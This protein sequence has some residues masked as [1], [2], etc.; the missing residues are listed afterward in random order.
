MA[1][2]GRSDE[3]QTTKIKEKVEPASCDHG[4]LIARD[5]AS[6]E[7]FKLPKQNRRSGYQAR[8]LL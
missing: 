7:P 4:P 3:D 1:A 6:Y 5:V 8:I 2:C